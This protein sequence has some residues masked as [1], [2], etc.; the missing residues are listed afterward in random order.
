MREKLIFPEYA[1][2]GRAQMGLHHILYELGARVNAKEVWRR[3]F[4]DFKV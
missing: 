4:A 1:L 3:V 2:I